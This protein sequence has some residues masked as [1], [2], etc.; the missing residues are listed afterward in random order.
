MILRPKKWKKNSYVFYLS[1]GEI[2]FKRWT[3]Y[4]F[5]PKDKLYCFIF[6]RWSASFA[7]NA[8]VPR[9][10]IH[11]HTHTKHIHVS[12][13]NGSTMDSCGSSRSAKIEGKI[14]LS[15]I[16]C[17][18]MWN[19]EKKHQR[20]TNDPYRV[21]RYQIFRTFGTE[22]ILCESSIGDIH[23]RYSWKFE[24]VSVTRLFCTSLHTHTR[25]FANVAT[26][27]S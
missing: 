4:D 19:W 3:D 15:W 7:S 18:D 6:I 10:K 22:A 23:S 8:S 26:I 24:N 12:S 5:V 21:S 25:S 16:F 17:I 27:D 2:F 14:A 13:R 9:S 11:T 1:K 20:K